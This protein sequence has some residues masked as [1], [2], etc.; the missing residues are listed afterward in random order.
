MGVQNGAG[1]AIGG[2]TRGPHPT[3]ID[4]FVCDAFGLFRRVCRLD[5]ILNGRQ[6]E[7]DPTIARAQRRRTARTLEILVCRGALLHR[8]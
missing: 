2:N 1:P 3:G 7:I 8:P 6:I 5:D 4:F